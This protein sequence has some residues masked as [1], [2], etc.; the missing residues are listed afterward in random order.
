[1]NKNIIYIVVWVFVLVLWSCSISW[2]RND[3]LIIDDIEL[4][5][6]ITS[7]STIEPEWEKISL[8]EEYMNNKTWNLKCILH[9]E[10]EW[11]TVDQIVYIS[12]LKMRMDATVK[13]QGNISESHI[14]N[15]G[16]YTYIWWNGWNFKMK[17][18]AKI[19]KEMKEDEKNDEYSKHETDLKKI[20]EKIP[21]NNCVRWDIDEDIFKM[22]EWIEFKNF[23]E[24]FKSG[25]D[26]KGINN[27]IKNMEVKNDSL[28]NLPNN[29]NSE[30]IMES[31]KDLTP[32]GWEKSEILIKD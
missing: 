29:V 14:L 31:I 16:E 23:G 15:S 1:M 20:L 6:G 17:N 18:D 3:K 9:I 12:G 2:P 30:Q 26:I 27:T 22:P 19:L 4:G 21:N 25:I 11:G 10:K 7:S 13:Y 5:T 28:K 32:D 24:D 8:L